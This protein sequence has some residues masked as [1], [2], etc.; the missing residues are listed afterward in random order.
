MDT[1]RVCHF[2]G[3]NGN[4]DRVGNSIHLAAVQAAR[5]D[6]AVNRC[7]VQWPKFCL[8]FCAALRGANPRGERISTMILAVGPMLRRIP[9]MDLLFGD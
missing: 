2:F 1:L 5:N 4:T 9:L 6:Y 7:G 8:D 3:V